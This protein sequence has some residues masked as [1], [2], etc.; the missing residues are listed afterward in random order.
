[1][2]SNTLTRV[3]TTAVEIPVRGSNR[4]RGPHVGMRRQRSL[5]GVVDAGGLIAGLG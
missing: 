2:P 4:D 1:M 5:V 3:Q